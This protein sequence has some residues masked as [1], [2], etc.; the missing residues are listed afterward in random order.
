MD[1]E[2]ECLSLKSN[3]TQDDQLGPGKVSPDHH[4]GIRNNGSCAKE[5]VDR[6]GS[7]EN[8]GDNWPEDVDSPPQ[9][10][11]SN[12]SESKSPGG[13]SP[14]T[15]KGFGLKKWR[16]IRRDFFKDSVA[17]L[18]DNDSSKMLKRVLPSNANPI[19]TQHSGLDINVGAVDGF[20]IRGSGSDSRNAVGSVFAAGTDSE[21][22]EDRSSKSS[23]AASAP[24]ARLDLPAMMG[25]MRDKNKA[26][27]GV[28]KSFGNSSSQRVPLGKGG[29]VESSKKARGE[30]VKIE[31]ENSYSS[32]ES[33]S[34]SSNVFFMQSTNVTSNGKQTG[35]RSLSY[36]EENSDEAHES[37]QQFS[38]EVQTGYS[39]ENVGDVEDSQ[40]DSA[41]D[42]SWGIK[43]ES[44]TN[45]DPL[46]D[47][48]LSLQSVQEALEREVQELGQIGKEPIA[49]LDKLM[50]N[51]SVSADFTE[52]GTQEPNQSNQLGSDKTMQT[53]VSSLQ[54]KVSSLE[55][56]VNVLETELG[57]A[58]AI[59]VAKESKVTELEATIKSI[60]SPKE[61]SGSAIDLEEKKHKETEND[62]ESLFK[63]RIEAEIEYLALTRAT[64]SL[65]T[66]AGNQAMILKEQETVAKEQAR[67]LNRLGDVANKAANLK[68]EAQEF[69][70][71]HGDILETEELS[72]NP[73]EVAP[74]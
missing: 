13:V 66:L 45:R 8:L 21:N 40:G 74:T 2:S 22:S 61:E 41:A 10:A 3:S 60:K 58:R 55:E 11:N 46:A 9:P 71:Y 53:V 4:N 30:R 39:K 57:E 7:S 72:P 12:P 54:A 63:Q 14:A 19:K 52:L 69:E 5:V 64:Q 36:D 18:V 59:L 51:S 32:V 73:G 56:N 38:E 33:D 50:E 34:R 17:T 25:H 26:K 15:T 48:I 1:L 24:K 49:S 42:V 44:L 70:K 68:K 16:R 67:V 29:K 35:R 27:S 6:L 20:T 28:G 37:E 47:S 31:K 62:I 43:E 23:T 65:K